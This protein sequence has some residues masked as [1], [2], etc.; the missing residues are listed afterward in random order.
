MLL[1]LSEHRLIGQP[2]IQ[3]ITAKEMEERGALT[4]DEALKGVPELW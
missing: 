4:V 2:N 1:N 3:V